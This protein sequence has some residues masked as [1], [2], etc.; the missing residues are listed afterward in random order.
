MRHTTLLTVAFIA[1]GSAATVMQSGAQTPP[2]ASAPPALRDTVVPPALAQIRPGRYVRIE[3]NAGRRVTGMLH[4]PI[5]VSV[6][7]KPHGHEGRT[8]E[9]TPLAEVRSTWR[10]GSHARGGAIAGAVIGGLLSVAVSSAISFGAPAEPQASG[11]FGG[12]AI[13]G[14]IGGLAGALVGNWRL[15]HESRTP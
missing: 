7:L 10:A 12:V 13:G 3:T 8:I 2:P 4:E 5:G 15:V 14:L 1:V 9:R 11:L 6:A